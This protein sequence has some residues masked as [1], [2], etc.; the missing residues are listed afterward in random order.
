MEKILKLREIL[1][2]IF[3]IDICLNVFI[4]YF[5]YGDLNRFDYVIR[6]IQLFVKIVVDYMFMFYWWYPVRYEEYDEKNPDLHIM[7]LALVLCIGF[8]LLLKFINKLSIHSMVVDLI[9]FLC[10]FVLFR[11][12]DYCRDL[13]LDKE[14]I[15]QIKKDNMCIVSLIGMSFIYTTLFSFCKNISISAVISIGY[16]CFV[17]WCALI[18][19][20]HLLHHKF[21]Y[22]LKKK[23]MLIIFSC[24]A[25]FL[26]FFLFCFFVNKGMLI[27]TIVMRICYFLLALL[28]T[29]MYMYVLNETIYIEKKNID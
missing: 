11:Y 20:I 13:D 18:N 17:V 22:E 26:L 27:E 10:V 24:P 2:Y 23:N 7:E 28:G 8:V 4:L 21:C 25:L 3:I 12:L 16:T 9:I 1:I 15:H 29:L 14:F 6:C 19:Q 5:D